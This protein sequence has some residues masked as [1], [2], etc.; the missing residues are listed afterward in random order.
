MYVS[1]FEMDYLEDLGLLKMD[2]LGNRNLTTI[3]DIIEKVKIYENKDIDFL[4]IPLDDKDTLRL[5]YDVNTNGIFQFESDVMK[6]LLKK[7]K[8]TTFDDIV[9]ADALV[10][11]GPDTNA[12][13]ERKNN[14]IIITYP[15]KEIE[16]VLSKTYGVMV[17][18]EQI[19]QIANI[20]SGFSLS[21]ADILRRAMGKKKKEI[22]EV[23]EKKFMDG[24][25]KNG[26]SYD[27]A[28]K[29]YDDIL[30]FAEYGFNK[31]H[32]V[33]YSMIA[34][35]MGYLKVHY[36]KYF[37]LSLLSMLIGN[38]DKTLSIIREAR[39]NGVEFYL[40][41]INTSTE[42]YE[43]KENGILFPLS[44]I[45][46]IGM[47]TAVEIVNARKNGFKNIF[48]AFTRLVDIGINRKTIES[49]IYAS[50]FDE[51]GYNKNTLI[52]NLDNLLTYAFIAKGISSDIIEPPTIIEYDEFSNDVLMSW[53]KDLFGF[54]LSYYPTSKYK[55]KYKVV[56]LNDLGLYNNKL[57]DTIILVERIKMHQDKKGNTMA[58]MTGSDEFTSCDYIFF[59]N[60]YSTI[61]EVKKGDILLVRGKVEKQ[62]KYKIIVDKVK[63]IS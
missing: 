8:V 59:S 62:E 15:S 21:E 41:N 56:N 43:I 55:D 10:R 28:K 35:K 50:C 40:P 32:A 18:Q 36:A 47:N 38:N 23:Q 19:M 51:F 52:S 24:A 61:S 53:E 12:Y 63:I 16:P 42:K 2:F 37:Y 26:Y 49:L 29:F 46:N 25:L 34:Y 33:A 39:A 31:S 17:Y 58:F 4:N 22:L 30:S 14:N 54:Y 60:V 45:T 9:A 5:F 13:I 3:M 20:M 7:L 27:V 11:P 44:N 6:N 48:D 1:S 57:V